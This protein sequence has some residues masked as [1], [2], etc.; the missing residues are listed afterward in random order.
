[1][2]KII[3][4]GFFVATFVLMYAAFSFATLELN[5]AKWDESARILY[6]WFYFSSGATLAA[7][8]YA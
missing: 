4:V 7:I 1:M 6:L 2:K 5:P 3:A 8:S